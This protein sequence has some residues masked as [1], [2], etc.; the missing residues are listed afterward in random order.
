MEVRRDE[1]AGPDRR[2]VR[3]GGR[4]RARLVRDARRRAL[5]AAARVVALRPADQ[6]SRA[7]ARHPV[8]RRRRARGRSRSRRRPCTVR[9]VTDRRPRGQPSRATRTACPACHRSPTTGK[10]VFA[11]DPDQGVRPGDRARQRAAERAHLA[12]RHRPSATS[13]SPGCTEGPRSSS[14]AGGHRLCYRVTRRVEVDATKPQP[15]Y[16]A[17]DGRP[18]LAIVVCSGERLGPGA[19]DE[20]HDLVRLGRRDSVSPPG[21]GSGRRAPRRPRRP[22]RSRRRRAGSRPCP[23]RW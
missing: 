14:R 23:G 2:C 10:T 21:P 6:G 7:D 19:V 12:R 20:A 8:P 1:A 17:T 16:F 18:Q 11:F 4:R 9:G 22:G 3:A 5:R 13:C 15:A